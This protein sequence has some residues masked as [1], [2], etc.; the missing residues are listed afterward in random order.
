MEWARKAEQSRGVRQT[1]I[2]GGDRCSA[3]VIL[4]TINEKVDQESEGLW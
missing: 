2:G 4:A 1:R 3:V